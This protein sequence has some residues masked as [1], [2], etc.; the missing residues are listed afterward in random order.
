MFQLSVLVYSLYFDLRVSFTNSIHTLTIER[1]GFLVKKGSTT[2]TIGLMIGLGIHWA[3]SLVAPFIQVRMLQVFP[4]KFILQ[5][6]SRNKKEALY[7]I[8]LVDT[9]Q[10]QS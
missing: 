2:S 4:I 7:L 1:Q 6:R 5:C 9:V 10:R 8:H 3:V